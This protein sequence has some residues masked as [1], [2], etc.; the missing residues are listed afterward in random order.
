MSNLVGIFMR[1][2]EE[3]IVISGDIELM[4]NQVAVPPEDWVT[5]CFLWCFLLFLKQKSINTSITSS[6][7][8]M[9]VSKFDRNCFHPLSLSSLLVS[10]SDKPS[11]YCMQLYSC[12]KDFNCSVTA[13]KHDHMY[14]VWSCRLIQINKIVSPCSRCHCS[15]NVTSNTVKEDSSATCGCGSTHLSTWFGCPQE[16]VLNYGEC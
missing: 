12:G 14:V 8:F 9:G 2:W 4:F 1:F 7:R 13:V 15:V 3:R 5:L 16:V 10:T 11:H 6:K